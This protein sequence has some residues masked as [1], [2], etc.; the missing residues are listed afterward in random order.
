MSPEQFDRYTD[1]EVREGDVGFILFYHLSF[2][3]SASCRKKF[4]EIQER[5]ARKVL[6]EEATLSRAELWKRQLAER[7]MMHIL[8]ER[9]V[10]RQY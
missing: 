10:L 3:L 1:M 6:L 7:E 5:T 9:G 2:C 8:R 4:S